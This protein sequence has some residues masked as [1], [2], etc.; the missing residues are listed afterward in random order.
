MP[1]ITVEGRT[2]NKKQKDKLVKELTTTASEIMNIPQQAFVVLLKETELGNIGMGDQLL[3]D[4]L[5]AFAR[6]PF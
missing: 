6:T 4:R 5:K 2:L 3:S 1:V